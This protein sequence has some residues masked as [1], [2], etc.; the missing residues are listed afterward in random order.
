MVYQATE[1]AHDADVYAQPSSYEAPES[2]HDAEAERR[3][4]AYQ[5]ESEPEAPAYAPEPAD[6]LHHHEARMS[7]TS[8]RSRDHAHRDW[9]GQ[10][11]HV[12]PAPWERADE[13]GEHY[14]PLTRRRT[15]IFTRSNARLTPSSR[16]G[17]TIDTLHYDEAYTRDEKQTQSRLQPH[18]GTRKPCCMKT[19]HCPTRQVSTGR[20]ITTVRST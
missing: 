8:I 6:D 16:M 12:E 11:S 5:H 7:P 4:E 2:H 9:I 1:R 17:I 14:S 13:N 20:P 3:L 19:R 15:T 18:I 10:N